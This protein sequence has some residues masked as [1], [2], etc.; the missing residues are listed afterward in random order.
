VTLALR[1]AAVLLALSAPALAGTANLRLKSFD[2]FELDASATVP[3]GVSDAE[4]K[5]VV[6]FLHGSGAQD[7]DEDLSSISA[8]GTKNLFY[9]DISNALIGKGFATVRYNKRSFE[10]Q[11]RVKADP[12][13]VESEAYKR[14]GRKPLSSLVEDARHFVRWAHERFPNARVYLLGHGE[15]TNVALQ[16]AN[17]DPLVSGVALIG[18]FAQ[19]LDTAL[20]EQAVY[21]NA[22]D[23]DALD[24]NGDGEL[25]ES[26]L[27]GDGVLQTLLRRQMAILDLNRDGKLQR[28]EFMAG[29]YAVFLTDDP[30]THLREYRIEQA[31]YP[32]PAEIVR[33]AKFQVSFFQGEWDN[34]NPS[35]AAKAVQ[36]MNT[37]KWRNQNLSFHFFP[38]LGHALDHRDSFRDL[39]FRP[40]DPSALNA[41]ASELDASWRH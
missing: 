21:R 38:G 29:N 17:D 10:M 1:A 34:Q 22:A 37:V 18:F 13:F 7:M 2:G 30:A 40:I 32:R 36:L 6:V 26:E 4:V 41:M 25:D 35:Y 20:V 16:E 9:V 24:K 28:S 19:S 12:S 8:P 3:P 5:R 31:A 11:R 39:V 27:A 23:F 14:Y 15:G 33:K